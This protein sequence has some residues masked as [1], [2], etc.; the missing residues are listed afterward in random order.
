MEV[1][2]V[3]LV[4]RIQS[5][6]FHSPKIVITNLKLKNQFNE[7]NL[8]QMAIYHI[9]HL[10]TNIVY[11]PF[12]RKHIDCFIS[13]LVLK[14]DIIALLFLVKQK[15]F[16]TQPT[17]HLSLAPRSTG[18]ATLEGSIVVLFTFFSSSN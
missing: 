1:T 15:D 16:T 3:C 5:S 6:I 11:F 14:L 4:C 13:G 18:Q 17:S 8:E 10:T 2:A 7:I 12:L 9:A